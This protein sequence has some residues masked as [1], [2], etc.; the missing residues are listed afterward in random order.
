MFLVTFHVIW[1]NIVST[2]NFP[3]GT[4]MLTTL[5]AVLVFTS[6]SIL[7]W[8]AWLFSSRSFRDVE[9]ALNIN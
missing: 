5:A 9:V 4:F 6:Y 2:L 8:L 1:G 3:L 7:Y